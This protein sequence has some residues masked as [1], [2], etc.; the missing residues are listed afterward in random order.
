MK[1]KV[2]YATFLSAWELS[3]ALYLF[4][5][6]STFREIAEFTNL[7][8]YRLKDILYKMR[9]K[10]IITYELIE[11]KTDLNRDDTGEQKDRQEPSR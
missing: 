2:V 6:P 10:G 9:K 1:S 4:V 7:P 11:S 3:I 8:D 5:K